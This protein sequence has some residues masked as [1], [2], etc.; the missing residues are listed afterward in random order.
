MFKSYK[1]FSMS[2]KDLTMK[3]VRFHGR[4][5]IMFVLAFAGLVALNVM[6]FN[7][8][9]KREALQEE[10]TFMQHVSQDQKRELLNLNEKI[11]GLE[12]DLSR[13][14]FF[15]STL[16]QLVN[17]SPGQSLRHPRTAT[18]PSELALSFQETLSEDAN[19]FLRNVVTEPDLVHVT[20]TKI[21]ATLALADAFMEAAPTQWPANGRVTSPFG[22]RLSPFT[23]KNEFHK[24]MDI[25]APIGT[26]INAPSNGVVIYAGTDPEYGATII[27]RHKRGITTS[28]GHLDKILVEQGEDVTRGKLIGFVGNSGKSTGPHLHYEVV[29]AGLPINP[30]YFFKES[31]AENS[32]GKDH[33]PTQ[34]TPDS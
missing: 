20:Q 8:L 2:T 23:G 33:T 25:S 5:F 15:D 18:N 32:P 29:Y 28:Y 22:P 21:S 30:M 3:P 34:E 11:N 7:K 9:T 27:I 16:R 19:T 1:F 14:H 31:K 10:L 6:L 13:V 17:Q 24:G 4:L 12:D 26:P